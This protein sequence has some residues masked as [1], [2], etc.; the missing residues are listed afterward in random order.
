MNTWPDGTHKSTGN[1]FNWQGES[2]IITPYM[3][4][5][6]TELH[7]KNKQ[8]LRLHGISN[9]GNEMIRKFAEKERHGG[10][11]SKAVPKC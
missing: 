4:A 2:Q 3:R 11:Y 1:A 5:P 7:R 8:K 6:V 10:A 9:K